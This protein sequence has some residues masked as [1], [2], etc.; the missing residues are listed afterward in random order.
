MPLSSLCSRLVVTSIRR[1]SLLP[2]LRLSPC[3]PTWSSTSFP[4]SLRPS[5]DPQNPR[6]T[7]KDLTAVSA[8]GSDPL[9]GGSPATNQPAFPVGSSVSRAGNVR[10]FST[11]HEPSTLTSLAPP[12]TLPCLSRHPEFGCA[13][14]EPPPTPSVK[15]ARVRMTRGAFHREVPPLRLSLSLQTKPMSRH[16]YQ[17]GLPAGPASDMGSRLASPSARPKP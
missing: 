2:S 15:T 11:Q 3:R 5:F 4:S 14:P 9:D 6:T 17:Q 8:L 16:W 10:A 13:G 1:N 12:V 7:P